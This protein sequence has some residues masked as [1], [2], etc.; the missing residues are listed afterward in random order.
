[1]AFISFKGTAYEKW[2]TPKQ[3]ISLLDPKDSGGSRWR[4][5]LLERLRGGRIETV[6][7]GVQFS[8]SR[9]PVAPR[10]QKGPSTVEPK[11]W[12]HI[13]WNDHVFF[14]GDLTHEEH[15]G[16]FDML[17]TRFFNIRFRPDDINAMVPQPIEPN[18]AEAAQV[19]PA[20]EEPTAEKKPVSEANLKLWAQLYQKVYGGSAI[21]TLDFAKL[22]ASGMFPDKNVGRDRVRD[23]VGGN[24]KRGPKSESAE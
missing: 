22:S 8:G 18:P 14:S 16:A 23:L 4:S 9:A 21:D 19:A 13:D 24:R 5:A 11:I 15:F 6:A 2:L 10:N 1:M 12:D 3:A 20:T 7:E 17:R